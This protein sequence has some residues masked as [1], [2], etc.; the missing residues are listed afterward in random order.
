M[1]NLLAL[2]PQIIELM[3][4][5]G[6]SVISALFALMAVNLYFEGKVMYATIEL[7]L[8]GLTLVVQAYIV[9]PYYC[10]KDEAAKL[11]EPTNPQE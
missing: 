10:L 6:L 5:N 4:R 8:S 9:K 11:E 3:K 7:L 1:N 2:L